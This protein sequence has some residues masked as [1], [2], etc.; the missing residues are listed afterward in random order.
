MSRLPG[1]IRGFT[2]VELLV[3]M[4]IIGILLAILFPAIQAAR[5]SARNTTSKNNL[6]QIT[7]AF[8][9]HEANKGYL[10][11][12]W[13]PHKAIVGS[14]NISGWSIFPQLLPYLEQSPVASQIDYTIPYGNVAN[15][16]TADGVS[17]KLSALRV[18]TFLSPAEPRDEVRFNSSGV[19][20]HY[21]CNYAVNLG[22][23]F[24]WDPATKQGGVGA[25]YP[26]SKLRGSNFS[27]GTSS[28]LAFSE[29]KAWQPYFRNTNS[30]APTITSTADVCTLGTGGSATFQADSG[31]T[32]WVDGRSHHVGFTTT[33][34]PN[35]K[36]LCTVSGVEYDVDWNNHQE[37]LNLVAATPDLS[38][39]YAAV[40]ARSYFAGAVNVSMC[41]GSVRAVRNEIDLGV[42]QALSSRNGKDI[43]PDE[44]FK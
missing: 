10:P 1:R 44:F 7:L 24:V 13:L 19:A 20:Q 6:R 37:G 12:S 23:F 33:F 42:W 3:V 4:V 35:Q 14:N 15:V 43:I 25:A 31:H 30:A 41:D 9:N 16:T 18:P 29:V 21:P 39:T 2:L 36:V 38:P 8:L 34:R 40:T 5:E 32:E 11:P 17:V 27:D 26:N 28:T 22:P